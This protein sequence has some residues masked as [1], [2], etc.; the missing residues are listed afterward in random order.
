MLCSSQ[1]DHRKDKHHVVWPRK[2]YSEGVAKR[3]RNLPCNVIRNCCRSVHEMIHK[4]PPPP[5]PSVEFMQMKI[6]EHKKG[7]CRCK[8]R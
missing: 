1:C 7:R 5:R 3:Y 6:K 8:R 2:D 4:L